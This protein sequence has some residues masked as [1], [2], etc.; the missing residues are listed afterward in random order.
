M[1]RVTLVVFKFYQYFQ[2]KCQ[3]TVIDIKVLCSDFSKEVN[4]I[5]IIIFDIIYHYLFYV[6]FGQSL[7][8]SRLAFDSLYSQRFP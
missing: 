6:L 4:D 2:I 1:E 3:N 8:W 5:I 7:M